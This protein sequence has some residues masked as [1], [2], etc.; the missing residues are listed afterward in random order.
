ML[1]KKD[2]GST[3]LQVITKNFEKL[4]LPEMVESI[5]N[6]LESCFFHNKQRVN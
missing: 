5:S 6:E 1:K 4:L 3:L 2:K